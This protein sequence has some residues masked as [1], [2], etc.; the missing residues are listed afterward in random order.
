MPEPRYLLDTNICIYIRRERPKSVLERFKVLP[1]GSTAISVVTYGELVYG[2]RK[3]P[4][5][6]KAMLVLEEL[7]ALIPVL[8]MAIG[9]AKAYGTIRA[10]LALRGQLI[11][12]NDL[13][14]AAHAKSLGLTVVT[15]NESEFRRV[16]G[17]TV[18]NWTS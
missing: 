12:N 5:P 16:E 11:G 15:N 9:V 13:W 2:V 3:S 8:P 17:L 7:T 14:I 6:H 1:P 10:D 4:E 18:E